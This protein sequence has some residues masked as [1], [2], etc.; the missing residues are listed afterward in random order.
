MPEL[1]YRDSTSTSETDNFQSIDNFS[2]NESRFQTELPDLLE[3]FNDPSIIQPS[4][5]E[6]PLLN[7]ETVFS[8]YLRT[9]SPECSDTQVIRHNIEDSVNVSPQ[10]ISPTDA[11]LLPEDCQFTESI[12]RHRSTRKETGKFL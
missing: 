2:T 4:G 9:P 1:T 8:Q 7:E 6:A 10:C 12:S 3:L 11:C 5:N